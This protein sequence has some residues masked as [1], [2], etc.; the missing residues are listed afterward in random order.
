M[1][2]KYT[3][4]QVESN[5]A[6][7]RSRSRTINVLEV[8]CTKSE[9]HGIPL[10]SNSVCREQI[11]DILSEHSRQRIEFISFHYANNGSTMRMDIVEN[12]A[13]ELQNLGSGSRN[14]IQKI[15]KVLAEKNGEN[16]R[17]QSPSDKS[18]GLSARTRYSARR[19]ID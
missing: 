3:V 11:L 15:Q 8:H 14:A 7:V 6:N 5:L 1:L 17:S 10:L 2:C 16:I 12:A 19:M 18:G 9:C 13:V 4:K